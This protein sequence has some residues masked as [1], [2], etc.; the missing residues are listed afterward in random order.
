MSDLAVI[1]PHGR[2]PRSRPLL[3]TTLGNVLRRQRLAQKRTLAEVARA[4]KVSL[5]YLSEVERGRKEASSEVLAAV[6]EALRLELS[7]VLTEA[8]RD[9]AAR[10]D[11]ARRESG[12]RRDL[13]QRRDS[14]GR[15]ELGAGR[16]TV[17]E[18]SQARRRAPSLRFG[19]G[20]VLCRAA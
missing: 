12:A 11:L 15:R 1:G 8:G 4:A 9:L 3:R 18:L 5:P 16:S 17:T 6:C 10:R 2:E 13:A 7:D 19:A 14:A 20:D